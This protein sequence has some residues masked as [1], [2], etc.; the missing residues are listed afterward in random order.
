MNGALQQR[1]LETIARHSMV[2]PGDRLGLGVSGGADS[3]A[4][5]CLFAALRSKLGIEIF[6]LHF[7]HQLRGVE[8]DEDERFVH[9]LADALHFEFLSDQ[10]DVAGEAHRNS[11][12]IEEAARNL[13]YRFFAS[14]AYSR[15]LN[16]IAVAH[17]ADDQA[18]TVLAH[19]LR[20][21]GLTGLAGIYPLAGLIVRPL[22][23]CRRE[24][25]RVYLRESGQA[26]RE[27]ATNQDTSHMRARIRHKL[28]PL[29]QKDFETSS[30]PRLARLA[31]FARE[32]EAFWRALEEE[33]FVALTSR[34]PDGG[35]SIEIAD[36]LSPM[37]A[38][39]TRRGDSQSSTAS[40]LAL[41]RRLVRR[42]IADLRGGRH[43]FTAQH[44][45]DVLDLATKSS[46]GARIDL[47]DV[48]VERNFNRLVFSSVSEAEASETALERAALGD[49]F[50]YNIVPPNPSEST[51][52]AVPE[53]RRRFELK[54]IDWSLSSR[55]TIVSGSALDF[56]RLRWPMTLRNWRPGDSYRPQGHKRIR[57]LKRLFLEARVPRGARATWPVLISDGHLT[58]VWG[59]PVAEEFSPRPG[60]R[61]VLAISVEE[62]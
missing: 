3:V 61:T 42:I 8:A 26:W 44:V 14:I 57:K 16:R 30:V 13:R 34:E 29:L 49:G 23:E 53:I 38:L 35:I 25:L 45:Q 48:L 18:E 36:L 10:A 9:M 7:H 50:E 11:L 28:L 46:S 6:V 62:F 51:C 31:G 58:W 22:L 32:D 60:T 59:F 40:T 20:G 47:P 39:T 54:L 27:D 2:R 4:M 41:A 37:P 52:I 5:L 55:E 21:T 43:Q 17:T 12:N 1:V 15:R 33:R 24:E 56:A 19:L